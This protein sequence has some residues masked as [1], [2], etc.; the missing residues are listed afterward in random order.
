MKTWMGRVTVIV[1]AICSL[2][3]EGRSQG[4]PITTDTHIMLGLEG[5][6]IRKFVRKARLLQDGEEITDNMDQR[7]IISILI[8]LDIRDRPSES[9][10]QP[11]KV[12]MISAFDYRLS[13]MSLR[14][15][16]G[17]I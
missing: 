5:R 14:N 9:P 3:A 1:L 6:G 7:V 8:A 15:Y 10:T 13:L 17:G 12:G 2:A 4:L 16:Q 11:M